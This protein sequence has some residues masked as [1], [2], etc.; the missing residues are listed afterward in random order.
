M[1][2]LRK[3]REELDSYIDI[4]TDIK[5]AISALRVLKWMYRGIGIRYPSI[6]LRHMTHPFQQRQR[7]RRL[8]YQW[9]YTCGS[10][11]VQMH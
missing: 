6:Y 7:S 3:M 2:N 5:E 1:I 4:E 9:K 10:F 11:L 8:L